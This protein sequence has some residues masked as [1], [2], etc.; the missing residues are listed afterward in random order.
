M[1]NVY[2][3]GAGSGSGMPIDFQ[4]QIGIS[5]NG[6]HFTLSGC[7]VEFAS[8]GLH[9]KNAYGVICDGLNVEYNNLGC[10]LTNEYQGRGAGVQ[11][12]GLY[13]EGNTR[14]LHAE[15]TSFNLSGW[16]GR[17]SV[18]VDG[19][20]NSTIDMLTSDR[21]DVELRGASNGCHIKLPVG[22][23]NRFV[24]VSSGLN[25]FQVGAAVHAGT[26]VSNPEIVQ[27]NI[28]GLPN[29]HYHRLV[30]DRIVPAGDVADL[31]IAFR[32]RSHAVMALGLYDLKNR[33]SWNFR[34]REWVSGGDDLSLHIPYLSAQVSELRFLLPSSSVDRNIRASLIN[35]NAPGTSY[36]LHT[37][38]SRWFHSENTQPTI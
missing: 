27:T 9:V 16:V 14:S 31:S 5:L 26:P 8:V 32:M 1:D 10:L 17:G 23:S 24:D 25:S 20:T 19:C 12:N 29:D 7:Q 30:A 15:N 36:E 28:P 21:A 11:I 2:V 6:Q 3:R 18:V 13:S 38:L 37:D 35:L 34:R 4:R 22:R 33:L